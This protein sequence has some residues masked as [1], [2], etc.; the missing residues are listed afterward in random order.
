MIIGH[1]CKWSPSN[2]YTSS[3]SMWLLLRIQRR[4]KSWLLDQSRSHLVPMGIW[5]LY[6]DATYLRSTVVTFK[7]SI[8]PSDKVW[9]LLSRSFYLAI[10]FLKY[11]CIASVHSYKFTMISATLLCIAILSSWLALRCHLF[12]QLDIS[13]WVLWSWNKLQYW[14]S[15]CNFPIEFWFIFRQAQ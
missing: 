1:C 4:L 3:L 8:R 13:V 2:W 11:L 6:L 14:A 10:R 7:A 15:F 12:L 5:R 9:I